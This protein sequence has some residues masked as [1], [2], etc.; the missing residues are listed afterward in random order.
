MVKVSQLYDCLPCTVSG[1]ANHSW[2]TQMKQTQWQ[3]SND[4]MVLPSYAILA[5]CLKIETQIKKDYW[6]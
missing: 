2:M 1:L 5:H 6:V 3:S 4:W